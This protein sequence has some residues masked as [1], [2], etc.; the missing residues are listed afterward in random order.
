MLK[1]LPDR[2]FLAPTLAIVLGVFIFASGF[3]DLRSG[4]TGNG[5]V[6]G[7]VIIL[8]ALA[9]RSRKSRLLVLQAATWFRKAMEGAA[10][11]LIL[12]IVGLQTD[13]KERIATDPVTNFVIPQWTVIAYSAQA[14]GSNQT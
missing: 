6:S 10:L 2:R 4:G 11:V 8:G 12:L 5:I 13:L 9:Y 3:N 1:F 7:P 14:S